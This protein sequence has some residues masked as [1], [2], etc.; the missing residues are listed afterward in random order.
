MK[1]IYAITFLISVSLPLKAVASDQINQ[2]DKRAITEATRSYI[3][4][5]HI[6][7]KELMAGS[8]HPELAKRTYWRQKNGKEFIMET[9]RDTMLKVAES[10]NRQGDKFPKN[11][12]VEIE[13][14]DID[15]RAASVKLTADDW[16]DYMHL[17]KTAEGQWQ[18]L[19]VL[20]QYHDT[21][22]HSSK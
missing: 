14:L 3:V 4:S 17:I 16:I 8:L 21:G 15:Q 20:W 10:Y 19:N 13:V 7:S 12:R 5:Q 6:S 22:K 2:E 9:S 11:P 1:P 18:I